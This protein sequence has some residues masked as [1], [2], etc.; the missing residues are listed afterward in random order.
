MSQLI[1]ITSTFDAAGLVGKLFSNGVDTVVATSS[2]VANSS[3]RKS[4]KIAT[5]TGV[6]LGTYLL[7][8]QDANGDP[9]A[10]R[11]VRITASTGTFTE[12]DM[13]PPSIDE[14]ES[15]VDDAVAAGGSGGAG[16]GR[17]AIN[18]E[19][20]D[21][22]GQPVRAAAVWIDGSSTVKHTDQ[23][24]LATLYAEPE[25][26]EV[27]CEPPAGYED[28]AAESITVDDA[29]VPCEFVAVR[30]YTTTP[31]RPDGCMVTLPVDDQY[32][33]T[34]A[35]VQVTIRFTGFAAGATKAAVIF[36]RLVSETS[37]VDGIVEVELMKQANYSASYR[38][39]G[40]ETKTVNFTTPNAVNYS[41]VEP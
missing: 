38:I 15:V 21:D 23:F 25:D 4:I 27:R 5:F 24:G 20:L 34:H 19:V 12:L 9:V 35:G 7:E 11:P 28:V 26:Y 40:A 36:N 18:C 31:S 30:K 22:N 32:G 14:I 10:S 16:P 13:E 1:E 3:N 39:A 8:L 29:D 2:G 37:N 6:A 41:V 17:F 33:A